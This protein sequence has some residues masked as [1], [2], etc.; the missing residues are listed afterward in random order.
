VDFWLRVG[1]FEQFLDRWR[2]RPPQIRD[3][4]D[5]EA[6]AY[7]MRIFQRLGRTKNSARFIYHALALNSNQPQ[8]L[9]CLSDY[10]RTGARIDKI[11]ENYVFAAVAME[12]ARVKV[13]ASRQEF[14]ELDAARLR[15][16]W[17]GGFA[18]YLKDAAAMPKDFAD[19]TQFSLRENDYLHTI[20]QEIKKYGS[21]EAAFQK[22][23]ILIGLKGELLQEE[24]RLFG[25]KPAPL[26]APPHYVR[27]AAY[28]G[29]LR[30]DLKTL[31]VYH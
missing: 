28:A 30:T 13:E 18:T 21:V 2:K 7:A 8:A 9:M 19:L 16:I 4:S 20:G 12:R 27:S 11:T 3:L 26:N 22:I 10:F 23:H 6:A 31:A 5:E 25:A 29:W 14:P 15:L 24:K 17:E 1:E